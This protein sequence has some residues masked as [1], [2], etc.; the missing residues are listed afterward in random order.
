MTPRTANTVTRESESQPT[1]R[2]RLSR[3]RAGVLA[4]ALAAI[5]IL[6]NV[7]PVNAWDL[8]SLSGDDEA[9]L[10]TLTNQ[11]R[12]AAGLPALTNDS[13][14]HKE[15]EWRAKDMGDRNYFAHEIPPDGKM[16]FAG[17]KLR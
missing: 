10:F 8:G 17:A 12:A 15:A 6:A 7:A 11:D 14:L 13:Y 5:S 1:R 16:V 4:V 2:L 3:G 9:M